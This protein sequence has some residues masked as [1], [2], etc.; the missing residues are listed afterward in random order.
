MYITSLLLIDPPPPDNITSSLSNTSDTVVLINWTPPSYTSQCV[1]IA[2]YTVTTT[3][4]IISTTDTSVTIPLAGL[5]PGNYCVSVASVDT[6]NRTG[7]YSEEKC[8]LLNG[9]LLN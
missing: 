1:S 3:S 2:S 4:T 7:T 8:L 6:A 5:S 9:L